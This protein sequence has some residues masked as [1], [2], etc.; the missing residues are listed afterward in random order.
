[1]LDSSGM[2]I[3]DS[4][5]M[6][7]I[8]L[9]HL[10]GVP[11]PAYLPLFRLLADDP[12]VDFTVLF[13]S[14]AG[15][16]SFDGGFGQ[17]VAWDTDLTTG[18]RS[19]FL[20]RADKNPVPD[21]PFWRV[22]NWD[23]VPILSRG[24]YDI[25][26]MTG[27][28]TLTY[29]L[30]AVTQRVLGGTVMLREEQSMLD[31]RSLANHLAKH[32]ALRPLLSQ[33]WGLYYSTESRRWLQHY[34]TR[35]DRLF[36]AP[37]T[38]DNDSLRKAA[39]SLDGKRPALRR[40]F[41]IADE[42]GPIIATVSRLIPKKQPLFLLEAFRRARQR[43][44]CVL[45]IVGSGPLEKCL[46][47]EVRRRSIQ[48]VV[49][50]GFLNRSEICRAY[51]VADIFTL[52]SRERETFGLVVAEAMNFGLPIVVSDRVGCGPDLVSMDYNGYVVSSTNPTEASGAIL[53]LVRDAELRRKMGVAS[54]Q[55]ISQ[56]NPERT[57]EG[58]IAA[59]TAAVSR[60]RTATPR[61]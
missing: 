12:R 42:S 11:N 17:R 34:G 1:M 14:S 9:A 20:R 38:V 40:E 16:S 23:I 41:G 3:S 30:A 29:M 28:N 61:R 36:S 56:W 31:P 57:A 24:R 19:K 5:L 53:E 6:R 8:R 45:L 52:L 33:G 58:I 10:A 50:T 46:H 55:R 47:E 18:Y 27:Y 2:S 7:P 48:D 21:G 51:S 49:F 25:L 37:F 13:A 59:A 22:R 26:W 54:L 44:R 39:A 43:E 32:L 4:R 60:T 15:A 35:E